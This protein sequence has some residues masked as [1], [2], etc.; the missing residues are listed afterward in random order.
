MSQRRLVDWVAL[1]MLPGM[2]P[3]LVRRALARWPDPFDLAYRI[4]VP[5][6]ARLAG[7]SSFPAKEILEAR[8]RLRKRA[9]RE[10]RHCEEL[11]VRPLSR[12]CPEWPAEFALL[13]DPPVLIYLQ[14]RLTVGRTRVA[15]VG[16]R[17]CTAYG[18]RLALGLAAGLA[19]HGIE[20]VSGGARG[21]DTHAHTGALEEEGCTVAVLGSGLA[22]PYPREN[23]RLFEKIGASGALI[24]E[25]CL[26]DPPRGANFPRRNRLISALSAAVVVVE[27]AVRSGSLITA[28]HALEQGR[29]VLAVPGPVSSAK[30]AGCHQLIQQGAK[31]VQNIED[32][33]DELSPM[34]REKLAF[35]AAP[36]VESAE[37]GWN[38]LGPD[39]SVVLSMVD[40]IDPIQVNELAERAPF[41]VARLQAALFGL[42]LRGAVE[43]SPG[44]YYLLRPR[45]EG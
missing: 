17:S 16:S 19:A 28:S 4:P 42:E 35:R 8:P 29:E 26:E 31:L 7:R 39:E 18:R 5:E 40:A 33:L 9:E 36:S 27:A 37:V 2:G 21:V 24:S 25:F 13:A 20:I 45:K 3:V 34:Y 44:R 11:G 43:Q 38:D 12:D 32:I 1:N 23:A 30:S 6:L 41:G 15:L 10:I 14:G 22:C